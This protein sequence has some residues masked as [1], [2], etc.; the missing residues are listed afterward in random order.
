MRF[1][2]ATLAVLAGLS[3]PVAAAVFSSGAPAAPLQAAHEPSKASAEIWVTGAPPPILIML[4]G[5]LIIAV[6]VMR[7]LRTRRSPLTQTLG[8][9]FERRTSLPSAR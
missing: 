9:R 4:L 2:F 1:L 5:T 3:V 7:H 6:T 8:S